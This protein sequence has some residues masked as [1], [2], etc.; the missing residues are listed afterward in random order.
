MLTND[1]FP[2]PDTQ[3][4]LTQLH[5]DIVLKLAL[6]QMQDDETEQVLKT[7][8]IS[9][10]DAAYA[11]YKEKTGD[12]IKRLICRKISNTARK[13]AVRKTVPRVLQVAAAIIAILSL[14]LA[15][16][17]ATVPAVRAQIL[18]LLIDVQKRYTEL[19][20]IE[21]QGSAFFIPPDWEGDFFP[22]YIPRQFVFSSD[23]SLGSTKSV[24]FRDELGN[25]LVF[26][27]I[28]ENVTTQIDT[29]NAISEYSN[30]NGSDCLISTK[31][32]HTTVT[33]MHEDKYFYLFY[34][35]DKSEALKIA[36]SVVHIR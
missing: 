24:V 17:I 1:F 15:T 18:T 35:G 36:E 19:Q 14:G 2:L 20:L 8:D 30:I 34:T 22:S 12:R 9:E 3:E 7:M 32:N 23:D 6:M 28:S 29:E 4:E 33:W 21:K 25:Q 16:A 26:S 5:D 11:R 31:D 10:T 27:E 13:Q